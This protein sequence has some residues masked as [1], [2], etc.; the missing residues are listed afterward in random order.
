MCWRNITFL[1]F[2]SYTQGDDKNKAFTFIVLVCWDVELCS[3]HVKVTVTRCEITEDKNSLSP[4]FRML[5]IPQIIRQLVKKEISYKECGCSTFGTITCSSP[6]ILLATW[7]KPRK[8]RKGVPVTRTRFWHGRSPRVLI[9][10]PRCSLWSSGSRL[11]ALQAYMKV[12]LL[13]LVIGLL[14]SVATAI[15]TMIYYYYFCPFCSIKEQRQRNL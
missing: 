9:S 3:G 5:S 11:L 1:L 12:V 14:T 7:E 4:Y 2:T 8:P 10:L 13:K 6:G 15:I